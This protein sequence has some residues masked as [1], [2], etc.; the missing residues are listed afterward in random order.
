MS[1]LPRLVATLALAVLATLLPG[2]ATSPASASLAPLAPVDPDA[3]PQ[4]N[5]DE[6]ETR[7][8]HLINKRRVA[9]DRVPVRRIQSCQDTGAERWAQKL[10]TVDTK[11]HR[12]MGKVLRDCR[13]QWVGEVIAWGGGDP[14]PRQIVD[15]WM[16]SEGH[17]T[18]IMKGRARVAGIGVRRADDGELNIVLTFGQ[19]R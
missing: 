16:A 18:V 9:R 14:T 5:L 4:K 2:L 19:R 11:A 8:V 6:F 13:L 17:R 10:T 1:R 15:A 7:V 12:D 3:D